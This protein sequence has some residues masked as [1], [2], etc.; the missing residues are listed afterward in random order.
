MVTNSVIFGLFGNYETKRARPGNAKPG[1]EKVPLRRFPVLRKRY[2]Y[3]E[4]DTRN[5]V[6][7]EMSGEVKGGIRMSS[8]E[9]H[10]SKKLERII[11]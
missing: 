5:K 7:G 3:G 10:D 11:G 1:S 9:W 2:M 6:E 8:K 4:H